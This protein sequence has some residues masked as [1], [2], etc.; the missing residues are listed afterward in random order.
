M[1]AEAS[2]DPSESMIMWRLFLGAAVVMAIVDTAQAQ[3]DT[4]F[5][6]VNQPG[7]TIREFYF[8]SSP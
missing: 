7:F 4:R 2:D 3:C 1:R 5:S 8:G 6:L